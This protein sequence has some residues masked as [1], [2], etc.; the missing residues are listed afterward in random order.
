[1]SQ[2][3]SYLGSFLMLASGISALSLVQILH[4][5]FNRGFWKR[6][7]KKSIPSL[8]TRNVFHAMSSNLKHLSRDLAVFVRMTSIHGIS[9]LAG[10]LK[11][12]IFWLA[13]ISA[14]AASC[15]HFSRNLFEDFAKNKVV[16]E[17]DQ[18]MIS[19]KDV[20]FLYLRQIIVYLFF[21]Y[22]SQQCLIALN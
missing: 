16:I 14:S 1:M 4:N 2:A 12:R 9:N 13:V 22:L 3:V 21:R 10:G 17:F 5:F 11:E 8:R 18:E 7:E 20:I 6:A 15:F 19:S